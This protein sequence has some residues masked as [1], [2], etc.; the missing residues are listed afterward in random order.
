MFQYLRLNNQS[1]LG[2]DIGRA[3]KDQGRLGQTKDALAISGFND[4]IRFRFFLKYEHNLIMY[5]IHLVKNRLFTEHVFC[6]S[7]KLYN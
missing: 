6:T 7:D 5:K 2:N 4:K 1:L 3:Y